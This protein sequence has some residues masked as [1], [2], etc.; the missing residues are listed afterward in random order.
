MLYHL[1]YPLHQYYSFF[2]VFQYI[3][4]RTIYATLTALIISFILGPWVIKKLTFHQVGERVRSD[5]PESHIHKAGTPTMGGALILFALIIPTLLWADLSNLYVWIVIFITISFGGVGYYDDY[6]KIRGDG[7]GGLKA[8]YKL[9]LQLL[10]TFIAS[11]ILMQTDIGTVLYF[12]FFKSFKVEM[13]LLFIPFCMLV[14]TGSS[15]AVNLT[16]GLDGLAIGPVLIASLTYLFVAYFAGH[17]VIAKYLQIPY[18]AGSGELT[19]FCGAI[20]GA[21]LG[22]LWFNTYPAQVFMG[23]VG[24]L[25]LGAALGIIAIITKHEILLMIV[26]GLFVVEA[27]SVIFQVLSYKTRKKRLF[28][29]APIHHHYELKGWAEPKI[30]VRF[31]IISIILALIGLS[32]LK[33]R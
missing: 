15:N 18:I 8:R 6:L 31:W 32:T 22:F 10:I 28:L 29:M 12:P 24:S 2:N 11:I 14:I 19:I 17:I 13:G 3:T 20:A 30:I 7:D 21:S 9:G 25:P 5:G 27:L 23:D 1:L 4:F 16:D 26:G 33:L